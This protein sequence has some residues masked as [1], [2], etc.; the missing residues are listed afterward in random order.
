M[1]TRSSSRLHSACS[2]RPESPRCS[3][4]ASR[5]LAAD[6]EDRIERAGRILEDHRD[7]AAAH[8]CRAS[9]AGAA[10]DVRSVEPHPALDRRRAAAAGPSAA[11]QVTDLP[12][13]DSPTRPSASPLPIVKSTPC[14]TR[15]SPNADRQPLDRKQRTASVSA[16]KV[17][18]AEIHGEGRRRLP[19]DRLRLRR[20]RR[21]LMQHRVG[22]ILALGDFEH[23]PERLAARGAIGRRLEELRQLVQLGIG[24]FADL[25]LLALRAVL[26]HQ[27]RD[28]IVDTARSSTSRARRARRCAP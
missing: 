13:P 18:G 24:P 7:A 11:S 21:V 16:P 23:P 5:Q 19:L 20:E 2:A 25:L 14:R 17:A 4:S 27:R 9:L 12:D 15:V 8:A 10:E 6:G 22:R 28:R 1:P 3:A 26:G